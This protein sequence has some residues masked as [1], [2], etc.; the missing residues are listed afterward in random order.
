MKILFI[1][2]AALQ[3]SPT[4]AE[5]VNSK[6]DNHEAK[7]AGIHPS[8]EIPITKE[9][10]EW[11]DKIITMEEFQKTMIESK[12]PKETEEKEL[13]AL[14]I[15]DIYPKNDPE[16]IEILEEKLEKII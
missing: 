11:A 7:Y 14:K 3:R 8:A 12:F 15:P 4:A 1:C 10:I 9:S 5:L 6:Y 2:T 13:Y 16:L